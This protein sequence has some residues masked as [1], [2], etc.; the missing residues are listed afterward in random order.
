MSENTVR[1]FGT[2]WQHSRVV[3]HE[4]HSTMVY[5]ASI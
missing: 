4:S 3:A 1:G 2:Y 5:G